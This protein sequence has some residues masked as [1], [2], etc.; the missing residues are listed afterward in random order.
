MFI[1]QVKGPTITNRWIWNHLTNDITEWQPFMRTGPTIS[2]GMWSWLCTKTT[3]R[4][5]TSSLMALDL[6]STTGSAQ[7]GLWTPGGRTWSQQQH[8]TSSVLRVPLTRAMF[9]VSTSTSSTINA[10]MILDT[11]RLLRKKVIVAGTSI[12]PFPSSCM[13]QTTRQHGGT[14]STLDALITSLFT[15]VSK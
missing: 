15:L 2:P 12:T 13:L 9:E 1:R 14:G 7:I 11:W 10:R 4:S 5:H 3:K 6:R 8:T